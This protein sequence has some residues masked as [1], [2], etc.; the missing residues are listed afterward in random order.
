MAQV[1]SSQRLLETAGALLDVCLDRFGDGAGG[2]FDTADDAEALV[3]RPQSATDDATPSGRSAVAQ[4][5][6]TYA[7][8]TGSDRH[9]TAAETALG[10]TRVLGARYPRA[11]G[12]G[13]ATAVALLAG[14]AEVAIVGD[15]VLWRSALVRTAWMSVSPGAVIAVR[16]RGGQSR[17]VRGRRLLDDRGL[18]DGRPAAYVCRHFVCARP[19]TESAELA[20]LLT[21]TANTGPTAW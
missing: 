21:P 20:K 1:T 13:L 4:A 3:R 18:V 7:A 8:L 2:F 6:L 11:A 12:W 9:R 5:L 14:P 19:V 16:Q 15:A 17:L 10:A